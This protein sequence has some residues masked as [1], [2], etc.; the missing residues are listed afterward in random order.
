MS[1][2]DDAADQVIGF[3]ERFR[4]LLDIADVIK[5][6]GSLEQAAAERKTALAAVTKEHEAA[7]AELA[8]T[9]AEIDAA[10]AAQA[11]DLAQH[12][13]ISG[14]VVAKARED[15][16]DIIDQANIDAKAL[17]TTT[18]NQLGIVQKNHDEA[19]AAKRSILS[20]LDDQIASA[21]A[22]LA[23]IKATHESTSQG[24]EALKATAKSVLGA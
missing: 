10:R 8:A 23:G 14:E 24:I 16:D 7:K 2:I 22:A 18:M 12:K 6:M 21:R 15:A 13:K 5:S 11:D 1:K 4:G 19:I 3:A 20:D 17:A 9:K